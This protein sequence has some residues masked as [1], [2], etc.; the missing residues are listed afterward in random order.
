M[1]AAKSE[2]GI[3]GVEVN[4]TYGFINIGYCQYEKSVPIIPVLGPV[5]T[6]ACCALGT[7]SE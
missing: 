4:S 7:L 5:H 3:L 2:A 6:T 1:T